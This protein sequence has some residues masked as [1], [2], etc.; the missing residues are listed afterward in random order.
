MSKTFRLSSLILGGALAL[1]GA[2]GM[3]I[4][5]VFL[6]STNM[7]DIVAAGFGFVAGAILLGSGSITLAVYGVFAGRS[8]H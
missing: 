4:C 8:G 7:R 3:F 2:V 1:S 6:W 5:F